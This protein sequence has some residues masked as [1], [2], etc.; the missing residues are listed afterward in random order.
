VAAAREGKSGAEEE[1]VKEERAAADRG[2]RRG[3]D[4]ATATR[5]ILAWE[6]RKKGGLWGFGFG[7]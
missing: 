6:R 1:E 7:L 5:N 4:L 3:R 2:S